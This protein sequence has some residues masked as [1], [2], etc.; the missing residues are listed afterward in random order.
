MA[1]LDANVS[2]LTSR[3]MTE[4]ALQSTS[5]LFNDNKL[6]LATFCTNTMSFL[7]H[8]AAG[9]QP[10]WDVMI[11]AA[12]MADRAG[13]E[14]LVPVARWKGYLDDRPD[15]VSNVVLD[16]FIYAA[17]VAQ[18]THYSAVFATTHAPTVHP[19]MLAKQ[20]ATIDLLSGG[21]FALNIVG[22]WNRREFDM[23][24]IDLLGRG[25]RY[26]Y[27]D[28]WTDALTRLWA[29]KDEFDFDGAYLKLK[30]AVSRPQPLQ[31]PRVPLMNAGHSQE[32]RQFTAKRC[33]I[34]LVNALGE[35]PAA[36]RQQVDSYKQ[37]ALKEHG[38][39][40]QVWTNAILL[41]RDTQEEADRERRLYSEEQL[42][43][44]ALDSFMDT[45]SA[46]T[47]IQRDTPEFDAMR[48]RVAL[49][50]GFPLVGSPDN[51]MAKLKMLSEAGIDG[52]MM[53]C[54]DFVGEVG[55]FTGSVLPLLEAA[56]LRKPFDR[57]G[58]HAA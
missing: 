18:A 12:Q 49:G 42:D 30:G 1:V 19:V 28:E 54:I 33:D 8:S 58:K 32:G 9:W 10:D 7:T 50:S 29:E 31:R 24:G 26:Q 53:N 39:K 51:V 6:K 55:R 37:Y 36:L 14:A 13:F 20:A 48:A 40:L 3:M 41:L 16:P 23:F 52:V 56:G 45:L 5:P 38:K 25:E 15:H 17:A 46:E 34:A 11:K 22:G 44:E 2:N 43:I 27:L 57:K 21:R 4:Q 47:T 35:E